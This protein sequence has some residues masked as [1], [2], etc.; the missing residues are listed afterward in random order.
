MKMRL[1]LLP[2]IALAATASAQ[3]GPATAA[4]KKQMV[5]LEG[6]YKAAK[7]SLAHHPMDPTAKKTFAVATDRYATAMMTTQTLTP[8]QRYPGAL[9]L[10]R[11]VLKVD[12]KN[13]EAS[14]NAAMIISV[15]KSMHRPIPK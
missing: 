12:P 3:S 9:R 1:L 6:A 13:K 10:Y 7:A 4:D 2:L 11:E 5:E 8:H 15:Y 14:N